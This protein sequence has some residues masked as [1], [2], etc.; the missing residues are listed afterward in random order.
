MIENMEN[1]FNNLVAIPIDGRI[2]KKGNVK[3]LS[4]ATAWSL[5]KANYPDAQRIVY[6][7][8][9]TGWNYFT[10][11]RGAWVK[12]GVVVGGVEHIDYLPVMDY[13][14][15]TIPVEKVTTFDV[16]KTIQ[17]STAKA[18]AMHGLGIQLWVGEELV[19]TPA[20]PE[21]P[22]RIELVVGDSNWSNVM[23]YIASNPTVPQVVVEKQLARKYTL[24]ADVKA[25]LTKLFKSKATTND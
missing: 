3:Y 12:V 24:T 25:E 16:Y 15:N 23:K 4:W 9:A 6:D 11:G 17:R 7:D 14:N 2:E 1:T 5:L 10:D 20:A 21:K 19:E 22:E 8:P 13:R 18:I